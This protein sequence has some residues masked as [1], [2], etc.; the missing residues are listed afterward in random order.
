MGYWFKVERLR[1]IKF[2]VSIFQ[3][4]IGVWQLGFGI[5]RK[6]DTRGRKV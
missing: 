1:I 5:C 6:P 4:I 2:K 3:V